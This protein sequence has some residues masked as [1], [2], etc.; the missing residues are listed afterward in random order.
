MRYVNSASRLLKH[1]NKASNAGPVYQIVETVVGGDGTPLNP[2]TTNESQVELID[3][4]FLST[5]KHSEAGR[6]DI[7]YDK[8]LL[9]RGDQPLNVND[10]VESAGERFIVVDVDPLAPS[11]KN[12]LAHKAFLSKV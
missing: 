11:N 12:A 9:T 3:P 2:G 6:T 7:K 8:V 10:L 1:F 5:M 4:V